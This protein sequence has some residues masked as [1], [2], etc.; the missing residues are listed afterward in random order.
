[1]QLATDGRFVQSGP[2]LPCFDVA[3]TK[4]DIDAARG[5]MAGNARVVDRRRF[6][7][8][9]CDGP[10][11]PVRDAVA[12]YRN[13][14]GG[15]GHGLEPD[16]RSP[17]SQPAAVAHALRVMDEA[18]AW[19]SSLVLGA[20]DWLAS[21]EAPGGGV[22]FM[23]PTVAGWPAAPWWVPA[24]GNPASP[25]STGMIAGTLHTRGVSHP[26]LSAATS[27]MWNLIDD[28]AAP[29][30]YDMLGIFPFL[31]AVPDRDRAQAAFE[32]VGPMLLDI[33]ELDPSA[34]GEVHGP[35]EFAPAPSS[36][37]RALFAPS[38]IDA[39]LD[40]LI[41]SQ[42]DDG[43]WTFNWLAWSPA[44]ERDWRG[45]LTVD[46]LQNLRTNTRL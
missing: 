18:D 42:Q 19:D 1:L 6:E 8:L 26:W 43:G 30:A 27:A 11:G 21:V 7:R 31:D 12:A 44:A 33:V 34:P 40:H 4:P 13:E 16:I 2:D 39:H 3:M 35:L 24:E 5:F 38:V 17:G 46:A 36:M 32:R 23:R 25:V 20:C 45:Y 14:D 41:A 22:A 10:A 9:F 29:G 15:F 28:L 37:A